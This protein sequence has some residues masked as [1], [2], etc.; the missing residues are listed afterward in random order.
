MRSATWSC[1][2][3]LAA[4]SLAGPLASAQTGKGHELTLIEGRGHL[5][6]F[7]RDITTLVVSEPKIADAIVVSPREVMVN[8]KGVG[9]T[10]VVVW[11]S[12][13]DPVQYEVVVTKDN[14]DWEL[15]TKTLRE[16]AGASAIGVSGNAETIV[17]TGAVK[18]AE[19]SKRLAGLAQSRSKSVINL[20]Q[21]PPP[22]ELRQ[23][24]LQVKF[25]AVD[26]VALSQIGFNLFSTNPKAIGSLS[27]EQFPAPRFSALQ[28][29]NAASTVNFSDLLNLFAF[30][31]D[32]NV[33]A[34]IKALQERNLLQILAE[35]NLMALEGKDASFLAGGQF[36]F[37]TITTTPTGGA[38][39]PVV[40][41][42]FKPF[43]VKLDFTPTITSSGAI[44]LKVAPEV[45]SLDFANA[46]TLQGFLIPAISQRRV[47]TEVLL[48]DGESFA[49]AGL[50]DN[51]VQETVDKFPG[52]G[53]LP[54]IGRF[55]SSR[56]TQ[57]STDE[58]LVVIT[59][60][61]VRPL[62][63]EEKAKLPDMPET[64]LP[65]VPQEKAKGKKKDKNPPVNQPEFVGPRG[66]QIPKQ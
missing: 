12:G 35:P 29:A 24:L 11:E 4:C 58:L 19:E 64:F 7:Q 66:Q 34:T 17:L 21:V 36:P 9:T 45:S 57:K 3:A 40:T 30:R 37:P 38:T 48:K 43:G 54:I 62:T 26:R 28:P 49:I 55:F 31:P 42:Q 32:L 52:I 18:S 63:S 51:R 2:A 39:A 56:S 25:A 16:S 53:N 22:A 65:T 10:T 59:P 60:H 8:A 13:S 15:F 1:L 20:L 5:L 6:Q 27:T 50:I 23:I 44:D 47:E 41:V 61:F 46:V 33:G 14:S